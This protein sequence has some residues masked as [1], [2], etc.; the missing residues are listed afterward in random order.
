M[1]RYLVFF[2]L[3]SLSMQGQLKHFELKWKEFSPKNDV[4][5]QPDEI[6]LFQSEN[7]YYQPDNAYFSAVWIENQMIDSQSVKLVNLQYEPVPSSLI[8]RMN[9]K[10]LPSDFQPELTSSFAR[11]DIFATL[12]INA[13]IQKQNRYYRLK[14]FDIEYTYVS[15]ARR[16][17][18][19]NIYDSKWA[20]GS[21]YRFKINQT[22]VYKLDKNFLKSLGIDVNSLDPRKLKIMGNGGKV[23]PLRNN[24]PY[25]ED[26]AEVAI[27]VVGEQD[28]SFDDDDYVLFYGVSDKEWSDDYDSNLNFYTDKT[29]YF[30]Q[31]DDNDGKR[32]QTYQ[33]PTGTPVEVFNSY[34]S[35]K[36]YEKDEIIFTYFGRKAFENPMSATDTHKSVE[37]HFNNIITSKPLQFS[38]K[39][40][41]DRS[42]TS[43]NIQLNNQSLGSIHFATISAY[44]LATESELN[45]N[46]QVNTGNLRFDLNF[47]TN[48]FYDA[49]LYLEYVNVSAYCMLRGFDKQFSF[50]HPDAD[51][52]TGLV[53]YHFTQADN[54]SSVWDI[55]DVY[56]PSVYNNT[57]NSFYLNF[58]K[59]EKKRFVAV[60]SHDYYLPEKTDDPLQTHQNLHR[61]VF[62][63]TGSFKDVDYLIITPE[64]L[65]HKAEQFAEMHRDTG[66]NV[67]VADLKKIYREFGN[68]QPDIAAIRNFIKY[69]YTHA[70]APD[71]R[72]RFVMM[73]GDAGN[74]YKNLIP[75]Y[76]LINGENTNI[77]PIYESKNFYDKITSIASD[78]FFVML[79]QNEGLLNGSEKP[80][81]AIGRLLVR[82]EQDADVFYQKYTGYLSEKS[83]RNWRTFVT[84]WADDADAGKPGEAGFTTNTEEIAL[85][86]RQVH[87]EYNI[88]KIYQDAYVQVNTPGGPRYPDA[89]RDLFNQFEKGTLIMAYIGHGNEVALSHERMLTLDD[90]LE[91]H[92]IERLPLFTTM[93]CEFARFDNPTRETAAE[94]M[95]WNSDGGVLEMVSTTREIWTGNA[96]NMNT[97]FYNALFG[98]SPALQGNIIYNPAEALRMAKSMTTSGNGKF[99]IAFLGDPG[100]DLGFA[101]PKIVLTSVNNQS[102]DTLRALKKILMKGEIQDAQGNPDNAFNGVLNTIVFDKFIQKENLDNDHNNWHIQFE[103]L[104]PKLFQGQADVVNGKF[105][106]EFIVPKDI[107]LSYGHGRISFYASNQT[108]EKIGYNEDI[109]VGG[110]DANAEDDHKPPVIKAYMN[111]TSF[112]PGG[113]T[114]TNPY[115]LL[116]LEDEHGINTI[117]GIGHDI[118]A[119]ID[120]NQT[121]VYVLNDFYETERNTYKKGKVRY[122]LYNLEPGWHTITVKAWDVYN[123]SATTTLSFQ[124][125]K[126]EDIVIDKVL[127]YPNPFTD[128]T[129]FWFTHNHPFE[130]LDV[131][132]KVFSISG[133]L[134][135]QHRQTV[136]SD[137]YLSREITW[138][139]RDNFGHKL[140]KGVYVYEI[141]VK[142][143]TGKI[144]KKI[145]KLVIL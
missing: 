70:S 130:N 100:F 69:V 84:F 126:N 13:L 121:E 138:D 64:F 113:I 9:F 39:A 23:M 5:L 57:Q 91:M 18:T 80:D 97:D 127:N 78:D 92:N 112:V 12:E 14:S 144:A 87:P 139:G 82:N 74:D 116:E 30:V 79:D 135:W 48:N 72:L 40:A 99:N 136:I 120:D 3:L 47:N 142:T 108:G 106:F 77:V 19:Q 44:S 45:G 10:R 115:L 60:D 65:H 103:Q 38:I 81:V 68:D 86:L 31:I 28:G 125:I 117:G 110:V 55:T 27:E 85:K 119:Y 133:K 73:F 32:I 95:L 118:T 93:T 88:N 109:I 43:L 141:S 129:E 128:Y 35:R 123:N 29:Y 71:K 20:S 137:N 89:K 2:L 21:W 8:S 34:L 37:I 1:K 52:G 51:I 101:K 54:I 140:A 75:E 7:Y 49:H 41:T 56:N 98:L 17:S 63:F 143:S 76:K 24:I 104:G 53:A 122:R 6:I 111:D 105:E 90:V 36:F 61:D 62:Y 11:D 59:E 25:P 96:E 107:N 46:T 102:A 94:L 4:R 26:I 16:L 83:K 114:D 15:K 42:N 124:V 50:Y 66:L 132:I 67:Y 22:G 33:P 134:V 131:N 145:E 58:L